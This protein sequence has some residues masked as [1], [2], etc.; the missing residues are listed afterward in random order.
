MIQRTYQR[1]YLR[2]PARERM[3]FAD[4]PHVLLAR[5]LNISED[6]LLVDELPGFPEADDVPV[7]LALPLYPYL[8]NIS[9]SRLH[10][11]KPDLIQK[12][13]IRARAQI[14]RKD[15]LSI[16]LDNIF[17][18]KFG[19]QFVRL[20]DADREIISHYVKTFSSNLIH[21][22]TLIDSFNADDEAKIRA[23][24]ISTILGYQETKIAQLR[25]DVSRDYQGLQWL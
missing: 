20:L 18:A 9:S 12:R 13:I 11:I 17:K 8:K 5:T 19:L 4:G 6:G 2:A 10:V 7:M 14:V 25:M 16:N 1:R 24:A 15:E 3:L 21:L 22:Q 23:R